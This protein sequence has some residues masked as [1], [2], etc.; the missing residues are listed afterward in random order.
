VTVPSLPVW[1]KVIEGIADPAYLT[2]VEWELL[3]YNSSFVEFFRDGV[4]PK[5]MIRWMLF[6]DEA[7]D[8][9]LGEWETAWAPQSVASVRYMVEEFPTN[10]GLQ[11]L[12]AD[13]L[14]DPIL[15]A[16]EPK[17][18]SYFRPDGDARPFFHRKLGSGTV[19]MA[20]ATPA[21][22]PGA[23]FIILSMDITEPLEDSTGLTG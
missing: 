1:K 21:S 20:S 11:E 19:E 13:I 7:R 15:A 18:G 12:W 14:A 6:S 22:A 8:E 9:V 5:N 3:C 16:I 2:N 23:R 10:A 4:P 17:V